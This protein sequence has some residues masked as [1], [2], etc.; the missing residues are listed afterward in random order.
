ML[1]TLSYR[2]D[3]T[4]PQKAVALRDKLANL[5]DEDLN[6][7]LIAS[8]SARDTTTYTVTAVDTE[9]KQKVEQQVEA[10]SPEEA[11][12]EVETDTIIVTDV[13]GTSQWPESQPEPR[14]E[15]AP[16]PPEPPEPEPQP[17]ATAANG[18][19][20]APATSE[21]TDVRASG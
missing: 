6:T 19:N 9:A 4:S 17:A 2:V 14:P 20:G 5:L 3:T 10:T 7:T 16:P 18:A 13:R 12:S 15:P 21:P 1:S 8:S 11:W